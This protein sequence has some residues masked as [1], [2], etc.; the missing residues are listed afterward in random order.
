MPYF[1]ALYPCPARETEL[2]QALEQLTE[3]QQAIEGQREQVAQ[4]QV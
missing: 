3:R 4:L 1:L 2:A